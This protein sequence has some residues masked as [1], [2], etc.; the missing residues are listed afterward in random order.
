MQQLA[1]S[2]VL[3]KGPAG[4]GLVRQPIGRR[5]SAGGGHRPQQL[6]SCGCPAEAVAYSLLARYKARE[7]GG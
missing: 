1:R 4:S 5:P 2:K 3:E 6:C 7:R